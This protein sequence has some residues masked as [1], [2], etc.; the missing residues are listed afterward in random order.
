M[1]DAAQAARIGLEHCSRFL[2]RQAVG[3]AEKKADEVATTGMR[4]EDVA[5]IQHGQ[6]RAIKGEEGIESNG[7]EEVVAGKGVAGQ[8]EEAADQAFGLGAVPVR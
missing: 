8:G 4:E 6:D 5:G 1:P 2:L 3:I 7:L